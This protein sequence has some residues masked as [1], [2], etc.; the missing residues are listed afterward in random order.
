M[1]RDRAHRGAVRF[2][3]LLILILVLPGAV[4]TAADERETGAHAARVLS[5]TATA[6]LHLVKAEG[7]RLTEVGPV[8][9]ALTGSAR[10]ELETGA[11][12]KGRVTIYTRRG[13]ITGQG[14]SIPHGSGRYQ[15]FSG[16]FLATSGSGSYAHISGH[17]RL[18][19]VFDRRTEA[20][21]IQ[22]AGKLSY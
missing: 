16:W 8:S 12:F 9:G 11:V 1:R 5:G 21:V 10:A 13:S 18:Y 6:R 3:A 2:G 22:T 15:S 14:R 20:I 19:G 17:A 7:S 4:P